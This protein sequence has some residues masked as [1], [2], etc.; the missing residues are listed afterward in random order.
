MRKKNYFINAVE[1]RGSS[2]KKMHNLCMKDE[3]ERIS[4]EFLEFLLCFSGV[5]GAAI[6]EKVKAPKTSIFGADLEPYKNAINRSVH[7]HFMLIC[8]IISISLKVLDNN[9]A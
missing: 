8:I 2:N 5:T 4:E 6:A 9:H 1:A 7:T 3:N